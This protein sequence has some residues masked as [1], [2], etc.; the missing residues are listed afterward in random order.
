M[1]RKIY[2]PEGFSL[3]GTEGLYTISALEKAMAK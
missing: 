3:G 2:K 1:S